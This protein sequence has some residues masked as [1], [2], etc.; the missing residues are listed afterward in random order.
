MSEQTVFPMIAYEDA[1]AAM[2]WLV[3]ALGFTEHRRMTDKQGRVVHGELELSG[4]IVM[5][6]SPTP[7]YRNPKSHGESCPQAKQWLTAPCAIDGVW[8]L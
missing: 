7:D 8:C 5:V 4:N 3:C 6:A 2:D 1:A